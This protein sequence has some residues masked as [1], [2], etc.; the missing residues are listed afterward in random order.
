MNKLSIIPFPTGAES[1]GFIAAL[2]SATMPCLGFSADTPYWCGP[3]G[4]YCIHCK[5]NCDTMVRHQEMLYYTFLT[6]C[7]MAFGFDYPEDD[8]A[9]FHT[10]P[11]IETGWRWEESFLSNLMDFAGLSYKR[12]SHKSASD[13]QEALRL[14]IDNGYPALCADTEEL[15]EDGAWSCCW[16]V[17]YGYT[18]EGICVMHHGGQTFTETDTEYNDWILITGKA[19][20]RQTYRDVLERIY[21]VL[22][23][24]SHDALEQKIYEEL[25]S[26]TK[27]NAQEI[28]CKI[29]KMN[30]VLIEGRAYAGEVFCSCDNLLCA[31]TDDQALK[32]RLKELFFS[33]YIKNDNGETHG[34]GWKIWHTLQAGPQTGYLPVEAS[35]ALIRQKKVQ[36]ELRRL[37]QIVFEN[38]RLVAKGLKE[39]LDAG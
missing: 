24:P 36:D 22:T 21:R 32:N 34:T 29:M 16:N 7:G 8:S 33:R 13:M 12:Y 4:S 17:V 5:N 18:R 37:F 39:V 10:I 31:L 9:D 15:T 2:A 30:R 14:A 20:R 27:E 6:A 28:S 23:D 25:S 38:D 1:N 35:F 11:G 19:T 3:K 26:V